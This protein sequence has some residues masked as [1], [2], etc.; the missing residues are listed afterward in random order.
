MIDTILT[1]GQMEEQSNRLWHSI[2]HGYGVRTS[3][4]AVLP[5]RLNEAN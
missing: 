4:Q 3:P 5:T 2:H 1:R